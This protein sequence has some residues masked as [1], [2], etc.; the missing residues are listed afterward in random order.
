MSRVLVTRPLPQGSLDPVVVARH[1]IVASPEDVP[2]PPADLVA[3]VRD[4]DAVIC[5]L[6]DGSDRK[7]ITAG[8]QGSGRLK[9]VATA[10]DSNSMLTA[11]ECH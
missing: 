10:A 1:E 3:A 9:V 11:I 8:T 7:V 2:L 4:V 5:L 6:S